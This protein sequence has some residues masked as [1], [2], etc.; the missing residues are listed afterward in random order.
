[1]GEATVED[2]QRLPIGAYA[3]TAGQK[4][5]ID[6]ARAATYVGLSL[7]RSANRWTQRL[8]VGPIDY[9]LFGLTVRFCAHR[10]ARDREALFGARVF[11]RPEREAI[12]ETLPP[13]GVF[14]DIGSNIGVYSLFVAA[15]RPDARIFAF[16]PLQDA[17]D[18]LRFN[19]ARNGLSNR[20]IVKPMALGDRTGMLRFNVSRES[21]V[22]GDGDVEVPCD[23]LSNFARTE[24]LTHIDAI[25]IDVE[26]FEDR[27]LFPFFAEAA[28]T[29]WP[30]VVVI[31]T[32]MPDIWEQDCVALLHRHGYKAIRD[33]GFNTVY[34]R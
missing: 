2:W 15:M 32:I 22:L 5:L 29:L 14:L 17:S 3:P 18:R 13:N 7:R 34:R 11:D 12:V 28:E 25:K 26:G 10:A 20:L 8:R 27:V 4:F 19:A 21:A 30:G 9:D 24:G 6:L 31:E 23:T 33:H 1:M 16:E